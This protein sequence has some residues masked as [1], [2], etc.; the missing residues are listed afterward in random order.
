MHAIQSF[1]IVVLCGFVWL[2]IILGL[3]LAEDL[4]I[5]DKDWR[6]KERIQDGKTHEMSRQGAKVAKVKRIPLKGFLMSLSS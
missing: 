3:A 2:T 4:T 5:Y 6:I 1:L